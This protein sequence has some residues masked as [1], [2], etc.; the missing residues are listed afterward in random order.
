MNLT[1]QRAEEF[2][3]ACEGFCCGCHAE[4]AGVQPEEITHA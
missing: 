3:N 2:A 4:Q 1:Y